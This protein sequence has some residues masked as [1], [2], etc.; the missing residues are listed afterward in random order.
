[1]PSLALSSV[2][3]FTREERRRAREDREER[4]KNI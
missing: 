1:M 2:T 4:R 3:L